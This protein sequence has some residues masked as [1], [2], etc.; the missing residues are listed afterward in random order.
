[1]AVPSIILRTNLASKFGTIRDAAKICGVMPGTVCN[2]V[3]TDLLGQSEAAADATPKP[4]ARIISVSAVE[5][6]FGK[7][8]ATRARLIDTTKESIAV[9]VRKCAYNR[10]KGD[11]VVRP[12]TIRC[13]FL[14]FA[15]AVT[16]VTVLAQSSELDAASQ[17]ELIEVLKANVYLNGDIVKR[18][19]A[20]K[21][22][23]R[24]GKPDPQAQ[25]QRGVPD[26]LSEVIAE[27]RHQKPFVRS[28]AMTELGRLSASKP[29]VEA[30]ISALREGR[31][32]GEAARVLG[33]FGKP[34]AR[35]L[36]VPK[37]RSPA[38]IPAPIVAPDP[39]A[40]RTDLRA[41]RPQSAATGPRIAIVLDDLGPSL[42][43]ARRAIAL[44][45]AITLAFLP[46]AKAVASQTAQA[47]NAGHEVLLHMP[48]EPIEGLT[49][50]PGP[51]ALLI[52][53][54]QGEIVRRMRW[55]M[56]RVPGA[57]GFNNHM[58]SLVTA[59]RHIMSLVMAEAKARGLMF[60]DSRTT[61]NTVAIGAADRYALP[62]AARDVF[63]D[64]EMSAESIAAQL[65]ETERVARRR[66]GAIAIGHPH[67]VTLEVLERWIPDARARGFILVP[68]SAMAKVAVSATAT[69]TALAARQVAGPDNPDE[70]AAD[71]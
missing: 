18:M 36:R 20:Q 32:P 11:T 14:I 40:T 42:T 26:I 71:D 33:D 17:E 13:Y 16:A 37:Y 50:N 69:P 27:T 66:G 9:S 64:N 63:L 52:A 38:P 70:P 45:P 10:L 21:G 29:A 4:L 34:A 46:Y 60:L 31:N 54:D 44:D 48:M 56:D 57:V 41:L 19:A 65:R 2:C 30:V 67:S 25:A 59:D 49:N 23:E 28:L 3:I 39:E 15:L 53:L 47:R 62:R 8:I 1:M 22:L 5:C 12:A 43:A 51:N 7:D 24:L 68:I 6:V 35:A 55:A 61:P 58:G